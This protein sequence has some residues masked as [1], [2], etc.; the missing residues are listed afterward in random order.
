MFLK[1]AS[2]TKKEGLPVFVFSQQKLLSALEDVEKGTLV[3]LH[4]KRP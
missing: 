4:G 1:A 2:D 3:G